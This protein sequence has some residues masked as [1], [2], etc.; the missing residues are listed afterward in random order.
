MVE[1][2]NQVQAVKDAIDIVD[3]VGQYTT[4]TPAGKRMKGLSPFTSEKTPSFFVDPEEGVYYCFSSQKGGDIFS[5]VQDTEGVDFK[6]A[7]RIL[8]DRAGIALTATPT[9]NKQNNA[10][11]YHTLESA[12]TLYQ[13]KLTDEVRQY[14][15]GRGISEQSIQEWGIGYAP[16][17]WNTICSKQ[18]PNRAE[19]VTAGMCVENKEKQSVYDRFRNRV[20]FPFYDEQGRVIGFS[21]RIYGE[22]EGAKY[23]NSPESPLFDKSSFLYG[24]H[25]AKPHIRKHNVAILTE[26]P[27]DAI[28]VHQ[29]GYPMAV[30]TSGT[31]ITERHLQKLQRLSN[32]LLLILDGDA[33]G[34]R[35]A[36]RVIEMTF[37]LG[38]DSKVVVLPDGSDPADVVAEDVEQFKKAV[39]EAVTAVSF[40]TRYVAEQYGENSEDRIR[41]VREEVLP[42]IAMNRDPMM[43]EH[44]IKEVANFCGLDVKTIQESMRQRTDTTPAQNTEPTLRR[45]KP[46]ITAADRTKTQERKINELGKSIAMALRFLKMK[47]VPIPKLIE[48]MVKTV[49]KSITLPEV[50]EE[51]VRIWYEENVTTA[52]APEVT[53]EGVLYKLGVDSKNLIA[54]LKKKEELEKVYPPTEPTT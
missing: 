36:L 5:F 22:S 51:V 52:D 1:R 27:I 48:E 30:A 9:S 12:A 40:L 35:A 3:V 38:I 28:M 39:K 7:L 6:E 53:I 24:L 43:R 10:P 20:Q 17:A 8:A 15:I 41:G 25:R 47:G 46:I 19:Q 29:A 44:A 33:A 37:T 14:L 2:A 49:Q 23:I 42:I 16:D 13:Q 21:G 31:A 50:D 54:E 18:S 26:G 32:R 34:H 4:L 45:K 11:L